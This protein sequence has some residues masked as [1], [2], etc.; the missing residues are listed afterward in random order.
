MDKEILNDDDRGMEIPMTDLHFLG[1]RNSCTFR[2]LPCL[3]SLLCL[4]EV[5]ERLLI[6]NQ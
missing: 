2:K 6:K 5:L 3:V 4:E 1:R